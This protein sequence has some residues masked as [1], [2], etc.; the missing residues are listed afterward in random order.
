MDRKL[1]TA[2]IFRTT[3]VNQLFRKRLKTRTELLDNID[4]SS[5]LDNI[6]L[7]I[8]VEIRKSTSSGERRVYVISLLTRRVGRMIVSFRSNLSGRL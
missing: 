2:Q 1:D 7:L 3:V 6:D 5:V 8:D 4:Q